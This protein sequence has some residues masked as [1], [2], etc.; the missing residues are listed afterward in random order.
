MGIN[1]F[2]QRDTLPLNNDW[3]F[4][5]DKTAV[6]LYENWQ[7]R[8]LPNTRSVVLPHTWNIEAENQNHYGWGWYQKY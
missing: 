1:S 5:T 7:K 6:G 3:Q 8:I 2:A 4:T